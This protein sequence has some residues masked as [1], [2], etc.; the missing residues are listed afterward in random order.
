MR[1]QSPLLCITT[2]LLQLSNPIGYRFDHVSGRFTSGVDL[3]LGSRAS[4][5]TLLTIRIVFFSDMSDRYALNII[6]T[7]ERMPSSEIKAA[8]KVAIERGIFP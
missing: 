1:F 5:L 2:L 3:W 7:M 4:T 8:I 6:K